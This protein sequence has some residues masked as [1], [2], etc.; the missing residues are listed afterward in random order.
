MKFTEYVVEFT[1]RTSMHLVVLNYK[2]VDIYIQHSPDDAI[3]CGL[4][5]QHSNMHFF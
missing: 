5:I 4:C 3:L 2:F 1:N